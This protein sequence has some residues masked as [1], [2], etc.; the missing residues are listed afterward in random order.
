[1]QAHPV[2]SI[3]SPLAAFALVGVV[4]IYLRKQSAVIS[5]SE[6]KIPVP[7][8]S[9]NQVTKAPLATE[10]ADQTDENGYEWLK[11]QDGSQ[12]YRV[13]GTGSEWQ[14]FEQ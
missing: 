3:G 13:A 14:K 6:D 9:V 8:I 2:V 11:Q 7:L 10:S 1:M 4:M 5:S 12:W